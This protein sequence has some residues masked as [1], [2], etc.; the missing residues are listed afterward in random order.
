MNFTPHRIIAA[1]FVLVAV[2][3]IGVGLFLG[4]SPAQ[5][6]REARDNVRSQGLSQVNGVINNHYSVRGTLPTQ[7]EY[8]SFYQSD[9]LG[10]AKNHP[11]METR[12]SYRSVTDTTYEICTSFESDKTNQNRYGRV[13][14]S[15][16]TDPMW[17][18]PSENPDFWNHSI[19][20]TCYSISVSTY[21]IEDYKRRNPP[22]VL[23]IAPSSTTP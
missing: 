21:T 12:P 4:G 22:A 14:F 9:A 20:P 7:D 11:L 19:G 17:A 16:K 8:Q 10:F 6:R 15:I 13:P 18:T 3:T 5:A 23:Q 2:V 1:S